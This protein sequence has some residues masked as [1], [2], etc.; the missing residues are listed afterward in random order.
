MR[1]FTPA[2]AS[3]PESASVDAAP[4]R[5]YDTVPL[6]YR[7]LGAPDAPPLLLLHGLTGDGARW[8]PVL[9]AFARDWR[10]YVADLRGH[11]TSPRTLRYSFELMRDDVLALL[12][13]LGLR[14]VTIVGHSLGA[15]VGILAALA[16]PGSVRALVLE[17][18]PPPIPLGRPIPEP[19]A[20]ERPY[21]QQAVGQIL[22]QVNAPD[23]GLFD[24]LRE[25]AVPALVLGGAA[26][27]L[28]QDT[29]AEMARRMP[30]GE[31]AT[32]QTGHAV[33]AERPEEFVDLV[34]AF[35]A[36]RL[37]PDRRPTAAPSPSTTQERKS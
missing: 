33:H 21:D 26:S 23:P 13:T 12:R 37:A 19:T 32:L 10:V 34:R 18:P 7:V 22:R 27:H 30:Q 20:D 8:D 35:F 29:L 24:R 9:D 15:V 6:A 31:F 11:G 28:P 2:S 16:D 3:V 14:E 17:E 5:D 36:R 1:A 4:G 25:I